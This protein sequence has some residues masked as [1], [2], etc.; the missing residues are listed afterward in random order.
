MLKR[1]V[2]ALVIGLLI[3]SAVGSWAAINQ[4]HMIAALEALKTAR[5]ELEMAEH[6]KGGHRVKTL[7][8]VTRAIEQ[9]KKGIEAGEKEK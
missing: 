7:E 8:L 5:A 2:I 3:G 4:P 1:V 6:N 9:T